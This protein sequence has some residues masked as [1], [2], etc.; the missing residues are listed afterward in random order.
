MGREKHK[1]VKDVAGPRV[2]LVFCIH[3]CSSV[4]IC[5]EFLLREFL[6]ALCVLCGSSIPVS[7]WKTDHPA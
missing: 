2:L 6:C 1:D 5:G 3:L 4:F 7:E